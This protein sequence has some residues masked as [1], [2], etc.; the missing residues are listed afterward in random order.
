MII[1][2]SHNNSN[3]NDNSNG[4][5]GEGVDGTWSVKYTSPEWI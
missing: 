4:D 3:D 2:I 1:F 5:I